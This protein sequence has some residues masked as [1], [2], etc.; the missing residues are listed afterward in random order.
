MAKTVVTLSQE[1]IAALPK[2]QLVFRYQF[3]TTDAKIL[4]AWKDVKTGK[5]QVYTTKVRGQAPGMIFEFPV[6]NDGNDLFIKRGKF[7][8]RHPDRA[9]VLMWEGRNF[10]EG[11]KQ[12]AHKAME[13]EKDSGP[14]QQAVNDLRVAYASQGTFQKRARFLVWLVDELNK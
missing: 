9:E 11:R 4:Y 6:L 2:V 1:E 14:L 10:E 3:F 5:D 7:I 12:L 13:R 8:G